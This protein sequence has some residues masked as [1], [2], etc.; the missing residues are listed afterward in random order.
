MSAVES[1]TPRSERETMILDLVARIS[2]L[3]ARLPMLGGFSVQD[4]TSLT[5]ER[6]ATSLDAELSIADV[7]VHTWPGFPSTAGVPAE[8]VAALLDL[9][10]E[11]PTARG[12][13][14]G[15]TFARVFH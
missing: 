6:E 14:R 10:D 11:H 9:L 2:A 12:L 4:R 3:F 8:I 7:S 15:Y 1:G 5:P 13:L